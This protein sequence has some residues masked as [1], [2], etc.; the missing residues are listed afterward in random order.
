MQECGRLWVGAYG[1]LWVSGVLGW[2]VWMACAL[3]WAEPPRP[4][5]NPPRERGVLSKPS[6]Q[7][8][9]QAEKQAK[10]QLERDLKGMLGRWHCPMILLGRAV[11]IVIK[12]GGADIYVNQGAKVEWYWSEGRSIGAGMG[13]FLAI[14]SKAA[15]GANATEYS[16]LIF[17]FRR[18]ADGSTRFTVYPT[19][20]M[21]ARDGSWKDPRGRHLE[22]HIPQRCLSSSMSGALQSK[23]KQPKEADVTHCRGVV[24]A[25]RQTFRRWVLGSGCAR[26]MCLVVAWQNLFERMAICL[27]GRGVDPYA[28]LYAKPN[29]QRVFDGLFSLDSPPS[30]R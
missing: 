2:C 24:G 28:F 26:E 1:R 9:A 6:T 13:E 17:T 12:Q 8:A 21:K 10:A 19:D 7:S 16:Y 25:Q 11:E 18:E 5:P 22:S 29:Q 14:Q 27:E 15:P 30:P 3:V 4:S 20:A 23:P